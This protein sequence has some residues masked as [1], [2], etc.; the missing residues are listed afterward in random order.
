MLINKCATKI[1]FIF[2]LCC[3][4]ISPLFS[5]GDDDCGDDYGFDLSLGGGFTAFPSCFP[6]ID[7]DKGR[8]IVKMRGTDVPVALDVDLAAAQKPLQGQAQDKAA[9]PD[10][11]QAQVAAPAPVYQ[12][13][14]PV[15]L[16]N[17]KKALVLDHGDED[18]P[19]MVVDSSVLHL[20]LL[21]GGSIREPHSNI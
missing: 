6:D 1:F 13:L 7:K 10:A 3:S 16:V 8:A 11:K 2:V 4:Y 17:G 12:S 20:G 18:S 21:M 15:M 9:G 5:G 14:P 19:Y